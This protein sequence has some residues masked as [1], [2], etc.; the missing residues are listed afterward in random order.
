MLEQGIYTKENK[1]S[2]VKAFIDS[3]EHYNVWDSTV[4]CHK[5]ILNHVS[6]CGEALQGDTHR[7]GHHT[8]TTKHKEATL[9]LFFSRSLTTE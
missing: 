4:L 3:G 1:R 9:N 5:Y 8:R 7:S 6:V 2:N